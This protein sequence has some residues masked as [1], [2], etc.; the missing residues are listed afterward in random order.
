MNRN[1]KA[2]IVVAALLL[3]TAAAVLRS[4]WF[5]RQQ[6]PQLFWG[7][8]PARTSAL[9]Y[10]DVAALRSSPFFGEIYRWAPNPGQDADYQNFVQSTGFNYER[11]LDAVVIYSQD[12]SPDSSSQNSADAHS[13][14]GAAPRR[15]AKPPDSP[16]HSVV[17]IAAG[18]WN[19]DRIA[20]YARQNGASQSVAGHQVVRVSLEAPASTVY[21]ATIDGNRLALSSEL[22][23]LSDLLTEGPQ[24]P[25][26]AEWNARIRRVAGSPVF[27]VLRQDS[28]AAEALAQK[29]PG[30]FQ[31]PQLSSLLAELQWTTIAARPVGRELQLVSE[32]ETGS[33]STALELSDVLK[34]IVAL[35]ETGLSDPQ[36]RRQLDPGLRSAYLELLGSVDVRRLDR[37][38]TKSVRLSLTVTPQ[39]FDAVKRSSPPPG[40]AAPPGAPRSAPR[41][42]GKS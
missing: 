32:G 15:K 35:A 24:N 42:S 8:V 5:R 29:A 20:A 37:G 2:L 21:F 3:A 17:A 31:S 13:D 11:D 10:V 38:R 7:A 27:A 34:G 28:R 1:A 6:S 30:G 40:P 19:R 23:L 39:F 4:H 36:L 18:R 16:K 9:V 12:F 33:E 22:T 26:Q 25:D 41:S 14:T